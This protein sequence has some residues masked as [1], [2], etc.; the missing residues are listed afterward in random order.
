M[1]VDELEALTALSAPNCRI[2]D[3]YP[4]VLRG[5]MS[6]F[7]GDQQGDNRFVELRR[8]RGAFLENKRRQ[9]RPHVT[10]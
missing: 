9:Y 8:P 4:L 2:K 1:Q 6:S 7:Q 3:C 5:R 10:A